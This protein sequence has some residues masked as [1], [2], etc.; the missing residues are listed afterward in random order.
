MTRA[1]MAEPAQAIANF[2]RL[3]ASVVNG[4]GRQFRSA[5]EMSRMAPFVDAARAVDRT[6]FST[7]FISYYTYGGAIALGLDLTLRDRSNGKV[8]LDDFMRAMWKAH[9]KPGGPEPGLV[10]KPYSL[11]DIRDRLAEVSGDRAFAD[12]FMRRYIIGRE[13]V[14]Y[15]RLVQR[16]GIDMRPLR[17]GAPWIGD[18]R[19]DGATT[20]IASLVAPGTPAYDAGL[21]QD[22]EITALDGKSVTTAQQIQEILKAHAPGD[23]IGVAFTRRSGPA[24]ATITLK[25]D[26]AFQFVPVASPT[27]DQLAFRNAWLGPRNA[28]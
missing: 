27:P 20:K 5:V 21:E 7:T 9:G 2:G 25:E 28:K 16:A 12:D 6:N 15:G 19:F 23:R 24:E 4:S 3:A 17:P 8:T 1:G 22:D 14:D 11:D 13:T 10:A 26:P 18:L